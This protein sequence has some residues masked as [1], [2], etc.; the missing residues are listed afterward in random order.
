MSVAPKRR[1][2]QADTFAAR[3]IRV[4]RSQNPVDS[5]GEFADGKPYGVESHRR[6]RHTT[7]YTII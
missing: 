3:S 6:R 1:D 7:E 4:P 2:R 5:L